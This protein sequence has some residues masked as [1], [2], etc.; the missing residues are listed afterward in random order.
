MSYFDM[1][2]AYTFLW[3]ILYLRQT[4]ISCYEVF[5][6]NDIIETT[7]AHFSKKSDGRNVFRLTAEHNMNLKVKETLR[8]LFVMISIR[9]KNVWNENYA[10]CF[11]PI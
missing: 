4:I 1:E 8:N 5:E 7:A 2:H 6:R 3:S 10:I 9:Q 11:F